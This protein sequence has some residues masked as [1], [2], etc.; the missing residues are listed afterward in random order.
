[1]ISSRC[2]LVSVNIGIPAW[3]V[4]R[5]TNNAVLVIPGVVARSGNLGAREFGERTC[6]GTVA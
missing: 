6:P 1:M 5:A 4:V 2:S 3:G